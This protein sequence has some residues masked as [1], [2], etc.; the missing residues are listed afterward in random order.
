MSTPL[1]APTAGPPPLGGGA[2]A[3]AIHRA[4]PP[5][6]ARAPRRV[7]ASV[8]RDA[9]WQARAEPRPGTPAVRRRRHTPLRPA[10]PA[11]GPS[12]ASLPYHGCSPRG[13]VTGWA[14]S[15]HA[16][17]ANQR[18]R[19]AN[20]GHHSRPGCRPARE[21]SRHGAVWHACRALSVSCQ[22]RG[23]R[24]ESAHPLQGMWLA[25]AATLVTGTCERRVAWGRCG[26]PGAPFRLQVRLSA[27]IRFLARGGDGMVV[28]VCPMLSAD[29]RRDRPSRL[30]S[31]RRRCR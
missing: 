22:G 27:S 14:R 2:S 25:G 12:A 24:F 20:V 15:G 1:A 23:R 6:N 28:G 3:A 5:A 18:R 16:S 13:L 4:R 17:G 31:V 19:G 7:R 30:T 26:A 8:S 29:V 11:P 10:L 21:S 9:G